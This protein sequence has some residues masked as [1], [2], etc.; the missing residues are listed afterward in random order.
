MA[1]VQWFE[2]IIHKG[3]QNGVRLVKKILHTVE[4][5]IEEIKMQRGKIGASLNDEIGIINNRIGHKFV[6]DVAIDGD[7]SSFV[8]SHLSTAKF[9]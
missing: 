2:K 4:G 6:G 5:K 9:I 3:T 1:F 7:F 8:S